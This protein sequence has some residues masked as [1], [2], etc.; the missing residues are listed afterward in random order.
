MHKTAAISLL[1]KRISSMTTTSVVDDTTILTML[2]LAFLEDALGNHSAYRRHRE[3][4]NR[5]TQMGTTNKAKVQAM[6][7]Q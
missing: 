3:Q 4:V 2:L 6:V 7:R 5:L 1:R